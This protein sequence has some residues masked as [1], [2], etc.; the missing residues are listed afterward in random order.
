V[1]Y[2]TR[3]VLEFMTPS[4]HEG[5]GTSAWGV[6]PSALPTYGVLAL[7]VPPHELSITLLT[8]RLPPELNYL[9]ATIVKRFERCMELDTDVILEIMKCE[10]GG[11]ETSRG[12][13]PLSEKTS[14]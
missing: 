8:V 11:A 13:T 10:S 6:G 5:L 4:N 2:R 12:G 1:I 3:R 7:H 14:Q 9:H